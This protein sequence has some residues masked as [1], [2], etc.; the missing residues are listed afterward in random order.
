VR[1]VRVEIRSKSNKRPEMEDNT[2]AC[3]RLPVIAPG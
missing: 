3:G 2:H 1:L